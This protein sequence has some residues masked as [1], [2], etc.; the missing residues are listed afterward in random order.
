MVGLTVQPLFLAIPASLPVG[1]VRDLVQLEKTTNIKVSFG[2]S[3]NGA[4][5]HLLGTLI[6]GA[7]GG[8]FV[9]VPYNGGAPL[10]NALLAGDVQFAFVA[11]ADA[12]RYGKSGKIKLL[13]VTGSTRWPQMPD[14][15]TFKELGYEG[16]GYTFWLGLLGPAGMPRPVLEQLQS[17]ITEILTE[18][19]TRARIEQL[20][21]LPWPVTAEQ[22]SA[23]IRSELASYPSAIKASG[24]KAE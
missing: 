3:G 2:S 8:T 13:A 18:P 22:F 21:M 24:L 17:E 23:T 1:N 5:S 9:H 20:S 7:G 16:L 19:D 10:L 14:I 11:A 15:A 4:M 12:V 6:K